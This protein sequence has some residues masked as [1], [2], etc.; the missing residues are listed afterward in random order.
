MDY[1]E[2]LTAGGGAGVF[3]YF[4]LSAIKLLIPDMK[5]T[6]RLIIFI[7]LYIPCV[8]C[9]LWV[10]I[11]GD[12]GG[13]QPSD[14]QKV[15]KETGLNVRESSSNP[16]LLLFPSAYASPAPYVSPQTYCGVTTHEYAVYQS[17]NSSKP[18]F[19]NPG[20]TTLRI[21]LIDLTADNN[22]A[23]IEINNNG[24]PLPGI[25]NSTVLFPNV[26]STYDFDFGGCR[27]RLTY[28]G[29]GSFNAGIKFLL[30]TRYYARI[31]IDKI[32]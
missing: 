19:I 10:T 16:V 14:S 9:L 27:F 6:M 29:Y 12:S 30:K 25:K 22:K 1:K 21:V 3:L 32:G 20:N 4:L 8:F 2:L 23:V 24:T 18:Y 15:L 17:F 7:L 26:N 11:H 5:A 28:L 13:K 31:R